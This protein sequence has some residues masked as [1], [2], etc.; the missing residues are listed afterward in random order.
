MILTPDQKAAIERFGQDVCVIAGPGSGKTRVLTERFA[1]LV[2]QGVSPRAILAITFT[3]KAAKE[4]QSRVQKR[5]P[6]PEVR[7]API[8]T[9]HGFCVR[10]LKEFAIAAELDPAMEL[11]DDRQASAQLHASFEE[12]LNEAAAKELLALR[13]LFA[14][15][16]AEEPAKELVEIYKKIWSL[17]DELP[18]SAGREW[19]DRRFQDLERLAHALLATAPTTEKSREFHANFQQWWREFRAEPSWQT[20]ERL[21]SPP[22]RGNL[23]RALKEASEPLYETFERVSLEL[24]DALT[25]QE[26]RYLNELL[27]RGAEKYEA[28]KHAAA[29]IDFRDLEH[30]TIRL[31]KKRPDIRLLLQNRYE[32]IL[33]DEMQDT[34]PVQ[35]RL[36]N[37]LRTP[38]GFF[39]V[40]D[41]NQSIYRFR[42]AAP[43]LFREYRATLEAAGG[44]VDHLTGNFRS[45]SEIL[46]LTE[47]ALGTAPGISRPR[48]EA[49][50]QFRTANAPIQLRDCASTNEEFAWIAEE[51]KSILQTFVV[52]DKESRELRRATLADIAIL[53]R[54][55]KLGEA[56]A[57]TLAAA[58]IPSVLGGGRGFFEQQEVIDLVRYLAYLANPLD[59][60][61]EAAVL[62]SPLVGLS[63]EDLRSGRRAPDFDA[64]F[65]AQR[66]DLDWLAPSVLL[67]EAL[68]RSGYL[69]LLPAH[70]QANVAKFL[71]LT[72]RQWS[73][74]PRTIRAFVDEIEAMRAASDEKSATPPEAADAVAIL[75]V[76]TA[77]GLE[78]PVVFLAGA[79]TSTR[80]PRRLL[81]FLP[82]AGIGGQWLNPVNGKRVN[83]RAFARI[84]QIRQEQDEEEAARLL[85]VAMTRAEQKL[86]ISWHGTRKTGWLKYLKPLAGL[87]YPERATELTTGSAPAPPAARPVIRLER[88]GPS[89]PRRGA[90]TPT[91]LAKFAACPR[92]YYL[93][94]LCG[95]ANWPAPIAPEG[96]DFQDGNA[97]ELGTEVHEVLASAT[98][99]EA[100][101]AARELADVFQQ[102]ELGRRA[103]EALRAEREFDFVAAFE[104]VVIEGQI[105]LWFREANQAVVVDYKTDG[106]SAA[107]TAERGWQYA[108]QLAV[109]RAVVEKLCPDVPV[110]AFLY[111]LRPGVAVEIEDVLRPEL[112][113]RYASENAFPAKAA[114]HCRRC[115]HL[116]GA[117]DVSPGSVPDATL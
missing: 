81:D 50:R 91:A 13:R 51:V 26:R 28:K 9:L 59:R 7:Q 66:Q 108:T 61:S 52:E 101:Q 20:L 29:R 12:V 77:K 30:R 5:L 40:G 104:G 10:A 70:R 115:P 114:A 54:T 109:Y 31:L 72:H 49:K 33:M 85:Y 4:I 11:W 93:D 16:G 112:L 97:K 3:E 1:W 63:D 65:T 84:V 68:D 117:C 82:E 106:V 43:E 24:A 53:V 96:I 57:S 22:K 25:R 17:S 111:F 42:Y 36:I 102:S 71:E 55:T 6:L 94:H 98:Q 45:R 62:R 56:I 100:S 75:T 80:N 99:G 113:Q 74:G 44:E 41:I 8:S 18:E 73:A 27:R 2:Q 19:D 89:A 32:H 64:F 15:W 103:G 87:S 105:D 69:D 116:G 79:G 35:W 90:V 21:Q 23:P 46:A 48:S 39:A 34:N 58:E 86:Y 83:D 60:I 37:L 92:R 88:F 38:G 107:E 14:A 95:L 78:F 110:R 76:H 67:S 47:Q